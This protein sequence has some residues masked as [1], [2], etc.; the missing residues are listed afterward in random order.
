M[1]E[2]GYEGGVL[3]CEQVDLAELAD[4]HGTPLYVYSRRTLADHFHAFG[5]KF[6]ELDPLLC[7]SAKSLAN[8]ELLRLMVE[9]GA[10]IDIVSGGELFRA[11][12]AGVSHEKIV[13]AGVGKT[14]REIG[15][16]LAAG[17]GWLNVESEV[18]LE[19]VVAL[20][21]RASKTVDVALRV[22]PDVWDARTPSGT[23]TGRR[24]TKFGV[25]IE[26]AGALF[27]SHGAD[28]HVRLRGLH[29]HLG[30]P[31]M[32][33]VAY[34][35]AID[36]VLDLIEELRASGHE[37]DTLNVGGG[38]PADYGEEDV[39][40]DEYAE[41]MVAALRPFVAAGG[42]VIMEPGRALSANAGVLLT[43]VLYVKTGGER[44]FVV[45]DAGMNVLLRPAM[46]GAFHF[47][48]PARV[49][50]EMTPPRRARRIEMPGLE[51][52]DVVGPICESSDWLAR[53]H[54]LPPVGR[55]DLLC[56]FGAG[57]YGMVMASQYNAQPR[58][59][60][61]LVEGRT[62]RLIR[63]RETYLDLVEPEIAVEE[64]R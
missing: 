39:V 57:A 53:G 22:N 25:D 13:F 55:G 48:W 28:D 45:V 51:R 14:D 38:I 35:E 21:R 60:E 26:R 9:L 54:D 24:G 33:P 10:G 56:V 50:A 52:V 11:L 29:V 19:A 42:K 20:A 62:A 27:E 58:P 18:E 7:F 37:V 3:R 32:A 64:G 63:R 36:R 40:W 49:D 12:R 47:V 34:V 15:E 6:S 8:V 1:D 59:A 46:Y 41:A 30:S 16:A 31:I 17:V 61:V 43:R 5:E 2:F 23:T 4:L 44:K